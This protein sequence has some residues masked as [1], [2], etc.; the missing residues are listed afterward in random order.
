MRFILL[1]RMIPLAIARRGR[2][3]HA[4]TRNRRRR[5][6]EGECESR[7]GEH[8]I[9]RELHTLRN[10]TSEESDQAGYSRKDRLEAE[11]KERH[12]N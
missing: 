9:S 10:A 7:C 5:G 11:P 6:G 1:L 8:A 4:G 2:P 3:P 12:I